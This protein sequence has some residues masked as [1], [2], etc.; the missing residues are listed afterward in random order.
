MT[1]KSF[2]K[3]FMLA[4]YMVGVLFFFLSF[5]IYPGIYFGEP[6][7][8]TKDENGE[9]VGFNTEVYSVSQVPFLLANAFLM[10]LR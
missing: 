9:E 2:S 10:C 7:G 5:C 3:S 6:R 4:L 8:I 1:L